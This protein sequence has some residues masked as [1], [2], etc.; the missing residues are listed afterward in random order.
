MIIRPVDENGDIY[1]AHKSPAYKQGLDWLRHLYDIGGIDPNFAQISTSDWDNIERTNK[2]FMRFDCLD[3]AHRQQE[4]FENNA[5][6][7]EQ[8]F[9]S[10]GPVAKAD[11]S[12]TVWPQNAGFNGEIL[13]MKSAVSEEDLPK[14][15]AFLDW[16]N[17]PDGQTVINA[18]LPGVTYEIDEEGY[19]YT[20]EDGDYST[21]EGK[22]HNN[23]NQLGMGVPGDLESPRAKYVG[24]DAW[25][26][27]RE[28]YD[29]LNREYAKYAVAN[30]CLPYTSETYVAHG[31]ELDDII[32]N[33]AVQYIA[34][35]ITEE[36]L[37]AEW[38]RW[39]EQGGTAVTNE[40]NDQ[41]QAD[42][43]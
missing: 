16:C 11:G 5:G 32:S 21:N 13:V 40:L 36:Q 38:V 10:V 28:R 39:A 25:V 4:W 27:A 3:N 42:H 24:S 15:L 6:V 33:A 22:Y 14:V 8:I 9:Q 34:C 17:S 12:V 43:E 23:L 31:K 1:P 37:R 7:T 20:P 18:G 29:E 26:F 30:P 41:Y 19:R 2:A 35:L